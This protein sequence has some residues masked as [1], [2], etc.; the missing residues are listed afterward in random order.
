MF[1]ENNTNL[2][3]GEHLIY[4]NLP[5]D[6]LA[7]INK[8]INWDPF[9]QI[10]VSLH[11]SKVGR[12][13]YNPVQMLKILIIQQIYG[14]SDP[15][16]ELMLKGN[17]FYRRFLG[18]SA[19]DPVPDHS[20]ISRFRSDLKSLNLY[21]RCFEELK[22]QLAQKGFEL[23]SGKI[24]DARLVKAARRPGK[25]DDASFT[26]KGKKTDY[27]YK[28]H[29]AIDVKNEF[30]SE[31]V[32][33]PAN[34]HDSQVLDE[35][36]E[37]EEASVFADKAYDKHELRR[38]CRKK[39]I[40]CGVLAKARRNRPLSARQKKRNRIFSRIRAKVERVFGI[41]SLHLQREK[42]RYVGLFANE[43]HL[44]LTCFTYNLLNLA[45]QMKRKEAI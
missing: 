45:W 17:L 32:C 8:L 12:K 20:T 39:G 41:F 23:R 25:D 33:T 42:A 10:L 31:F 9:Q 43:I 7:R 13:A 2:T 38:R 21:R 35:L 44:F 18:L 14:H 15:E 4:Q 6:I 29:I 34:V 5:D 30:V 1:R 40:F 28:D 36:L 22:R 16:M 3:I 27:G 37:G 19:I 24:I 11:P 26:Q